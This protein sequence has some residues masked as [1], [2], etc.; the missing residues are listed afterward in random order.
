MFQYGFGRQGPPPEAVDSSARARHQWKG[1]E[2]LARLTRLRLIVSGLRRGRRM[3]G[4]HPFATAKLVPAVARLLLPLGSPCAPSPRGDL[5]DVRMGR[6]KHWCAASLSLAVLGPAARCGPDPGHGSGP[7][8]RRQGRDGCGGT[9]RGHHGRQRGHRTLTEHGHGHLRTLHAAGDRTRRVLGDGRALRLRRP[10]TL[11]RSAA[12]RPVGARR[13]L[14]EPL[15]RHRD[16][17]G[18]RPGARPRRAPLRRVLHG[19]TEP[20]S[21]TCPS[22]AATSSAS[23]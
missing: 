6:W 5:E 15:G 20:R 3:A 14:P 1:D 12:P 9:R 19:G 21:A 18:V 22:T 2:R 23:R 11:Q 4:D 10:D 13:F 7:R 8:R 17:H 16:D